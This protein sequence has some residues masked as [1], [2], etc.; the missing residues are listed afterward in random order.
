MEE[1]GPQEERCDVRG[2]HHDNKPSRLAPVAWIQHRAYHDYEHPE[3]EREQE[4]LLVIRLEQKDDQAGREQYDG[5]DEICRAVEDPVAQGYSL[6]GHQDAVTIRAARNDHRVAIA[7]RN[8][9]EGDCHI[10]RRG[11]APP[12][13]VDYHIARRKVCYRVGRQC[14]YNLHRAAA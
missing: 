8:L 14:A 1:D 5:D 11:Y 10:G 12:L 7:R 4:R 3:H 6:R 9:G 2:E 13:Y